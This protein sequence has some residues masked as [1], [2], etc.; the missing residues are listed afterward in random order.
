MSLRPQ[1]VN[2]I[3]V[4]WLTLELGPTLDIFIFIFDEKLKKKKIEIKW[5]KTVRHK[6][7]DHQIEVTN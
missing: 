3:G 7:Y 5:L 2:C 1:T 6:N 4:T